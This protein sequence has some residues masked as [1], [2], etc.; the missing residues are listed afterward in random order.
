M[1]SMKLFHTI[2]GERPSIPLLE[3]INSPNDLR[4]FHRDQLRQ[5]ADEVREYLLYS[6]GISGGHFGAGLGVV[7]L[8]VALHFCL[9]TPFDQLVWDVGH[10]A[11]PHKVLTGRREQ[12][13]TIR[14]EGGLAA[15]PDRKES[16]YDTFGVGHSSTSISA[17]LGM[18][19]D[20]KINQ[21]RRR[22][23]AVIGDGA[24]TAGLAFEA[25][26]HAASEKANLLVILNDNDMSISRNVGGIRDYLAKLLSSKAYTRSRDEARKLLEP[27]PPLAQFAKKTEE[28]LKGMVSPATLFEEIGFNYIGPIDGHDIT[29]LVT[30]LQNMKDL[31]GPQFL[32]VV[33]QKGCG[34]VPAEDDPIK[35]HAIGKLKAKS[36]SEATPKP[37][38]S[39]IFGQWLC[40]MA[41]QD[42]RLVGI[43]PA[44]REGSDLIEFSNRFA[45]R[46]YDVAI[47]EQ[48]AVCLGAGLATQTSKPV[49]AIYS[50]FL[51]RAYDQV[52]H[53]V[54]VQGLDVTFAIDRA[55]LVG[56]DGPTHAGVYDYAYLRTLPEIIIAAPSSE[57]ECRLLLST[58]YQHPGPAA[59]RY[60]RGQ[61]PGELPD[62]SL[63]TVDVGK[64]V[65]RREGQSGIVIL[66]F[67]SRVFA[68]LEA[69]DT[70]DA[71]VI[72]MRWVKPLDEDTLRQHADAKLIV[73][74][75]EHQRM[76]GA[77]SAVGEFYVDQ[78]LSVALLSLGLPDRF[79]AHGK[80]EAMLE[81]VGLDARGITAAILERLS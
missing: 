15:F 36:D 17:A 25:L 39:N 75:E 58:C 35:Y 80:P 22:H 4:S 65:V 76:G 49:I 73:T 24:L 44:M 32:H 67:G 12:L 77:G 40:D 48:H 7:E 53:D 2:P 41:E 60:P 10:Q 3:G 57:A 47:A 59:V 78:G 37:T 72:D 5:V 13:T 62:G 9:D 23:V 20:A 31:S 6:V 33:T 69:A 21:S 29:G 68:A 64:A 55:G 8:T 42:S 51:Q 74:V 50:T 54:C 56:E 38:Y 26:N 16:P 70:L 61:G 79:E 66:G 46:Y 52:I 30:T 19:L 71:T 63:N 11:Y 45:D 14:K 43:T 27:L 81:R 1:P 18:A 34:F 28:H